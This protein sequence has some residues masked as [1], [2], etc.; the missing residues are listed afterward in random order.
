MSER[1]LQ[2]IFQ[3]QY[4]ELL[5]RP[6]PLK[7]LKAIDAISQCRTKA[8]GSSFFQCASLHKPIEL[9]HSCRHRSCFL[10][11]QKKRVEWIENQ[12]HRLFPCAHF[13]VIFTLPHE[14]LSLWRY[15]ERFFTDLLFSASRD[16]LMLMED[17]KYHG[18]TPGIMTAL[19]TW[20]RQMNLHPHVHCLVSAGG[21]KGSDQWKEVEQFLLPI[22]VVKSR[23]RA[24]VQ[25]RI[26]QAIES[27]EL[28]CPPD[29]SWQKI[30]QHWSALWKKEWSVRIEK[31]Y[32]HGKGVMLYLSRYLKGGPMNPKQILFRNDHEIRFRYLD[33]RDKRKKDLR[34]PLD[35]FA[36]RL[37]EHVP[38]V[39]LHTFRYYGLYAPATKRRRLQA[40]RCLNCAPKKRYSPLSTDVVLS[41]SICG[42][43]ARRTHSFWKNQASKAISINKNA[44]PTLGAG[45]IQQDDEDIPVGGRSLDTS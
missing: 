15:N 9:N 41:C 40:Y 42:A 28:I 10:C 6:Q 39:G 14:Y 8:M 2:E 30:R 19:H 11:A 36:R 13:H 5:S 34:L 35:E 32:E 7:N 38:Q 22:K 31:R 20:G 44:N 21:L 1:A 17:S 27:D 43:P 29:Q 24:M 45:F 12:K 37:L 4:D 16:T 26:M 3:S 25:K 33:H 18:V 23:Y